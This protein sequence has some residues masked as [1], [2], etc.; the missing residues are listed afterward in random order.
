MQVE[1]PSSDAEG[2]PVPSSN[3]ATPLPQI[4]DLLNQ[5]RGDATDEE[6]FQRN[7][8]SLRSP[9]QLAA[10]QVRQLVR[11]MHGAAR[12]STLHQATAA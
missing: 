2:P 4:A 3:C 10:L 1:V 7:L 11:R 12:F 6:Q 8:Q 5:S 9:Q